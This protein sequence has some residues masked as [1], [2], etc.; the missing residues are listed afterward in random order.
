[1]IDPQELPL[2]GMSLYPK[3]AILCSIV[4]AQ[5]NPVSLSAPVPLRGMAEIALHDPVATLLGCGNGQGVT[6]VWQYL[7]RNAYAVTFC[8]NLNGS[9][10]QLA[11]L[12]EESNGSLRNFH[13]I[14]RPI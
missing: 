3:D 6:G 13:P 5:T 2:K 7:Q 10:Y 14:A 4:R 9:P 1:M 8:G 11:F 12:I